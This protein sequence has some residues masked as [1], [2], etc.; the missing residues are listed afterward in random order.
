MPGAGRKALPRERSRMSTPGVNGQPTEGD[1]VVTGGDEDE[2]DGH[3]DTVSF[4]MVD[5]GERDASND[6]VG[7][8]QTIP[9][10]TIRGGWKWSGSVWQVID[11]EAANVGKPAAVWFAR[12]TV[13]ARLTFSTFIDCARH[14]KPGSADAPPPNLNGINL[15]PMAHALDDIIIHRG[16]RCRHQLSNMFETVSDATWQYLSQRNIHKHTLTLADFS[17]CSYF[18]RERL[19]RGVDAP[20]KERITDASKLPID[21]AS[22]HSQKWARPVTSDSS[23]ILN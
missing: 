12:H 8:V 19:G 11:N 16:N 15:R 1:T 5:V 17:L 13:Q 10:N 21:G 2:A 14:L 20:R 18:V 23:H 7:A 3:E 22:F 4:A 6:Q 9:L